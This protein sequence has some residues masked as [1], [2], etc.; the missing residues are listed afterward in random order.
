VLRLPDRDRSRVVLLGPARLDRPE[1]PDLPEVRHV[2]PALADA[3]ADRRLCG[4]APVNIRVV[5]DPESVE[6]AGTDLVQAAGHATDLLLVYL[7]GYLVPGQGGQPELA[8]PGGRRGRGGGLSLQWVARTL[9]TSRSGIRVL[10]VDGHLAGAD[11]QR[12]RQLCTAVLDTTALVALSDRAVRYAPPGGPGTALSRALLDAVYRRDA[13]RPAQLVAV[14]LADAA[15]RRLGDRVSFSEPVQPPRLALF[16]TPVG[17]PPVSAELRRLE[18]L[19]ELAT[20]AERQTHRPALA[21]DRYRM[22]TLAAHRVHGPEHPE[23]L[24]VRHRLAHWT[25]RSGD[26]LAAV[27]LY[28]ELHADQARL[29]GESHPHT[30][31]SAADLRYWSARA[32]S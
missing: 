13:A 4:V 9:A 7:A 27:A 31:G 12:I 6:Q 10:I 14:D 21:V 11:E 17:Q 16:R 25:G 22:L 1:L 32:R 20:E 24:R 28:T 29:M 18:R 2:L 5:L 30:R 19:D 8:L 15:A 26:E 3:F 23:T